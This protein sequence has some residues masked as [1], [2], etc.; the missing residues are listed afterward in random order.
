MNQKRTFYFNWDSLNRTIASDDPFQCSVKLQ[1]PLTKIKR[2][3]LKSAE[4]PINFYNIW[5][6]YNIFQITISTGTTLAITPTEGI[7]T[8]ASFVTELQSKLQTIGNSLTYSVTYSTLTNKLTISNP[9]VQFRF[10]T[11]A[12]TTLNTLLGFTTSSSYANSVTATYPYILNLDHYITIFI[13]YI[14]TNYINQQPLTFKIPLDALNGVVFYS[15]E[16]S[17]FSQVLEITDPNFSLTE[18]KV[19][20]MDRYGNLINTRS[21]WAGK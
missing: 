6:P 14:P 21:A 17:Q 13:D 19:R 9:N 20:V 10:T 4:I 5:S 8:I 16:N 18:F 15:L 2:I 11:G 3:G 12:I 7:Y 1:R